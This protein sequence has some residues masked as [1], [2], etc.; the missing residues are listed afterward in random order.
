MVTEHGAA[1]GWSI[2]WRPAPASRARSRAV[3]LPAA[4]AT[5]TRTFHS[6][7]YS[8]PGGFRLTPSPGAN[9]TRPPRR[10]YTRPEGGTVITRLAPATRS[11]PAWWCADTAHS[12]VKGDVGPTSPVHGAQAG[13]W[14]HGY[15]H[16]PG[17]GRF[18]RERPHLRAAAGHG[19]VA[20]FSRRPGARGGGDIYP[21]GGPGP[22]A[23]RYHVT[24][25]TSRGVSGTASQGVAG[26]KDGRAPT[27]R[28][29]LVAAGRHVAAH[30]GAGALGDR[31]ALGGGR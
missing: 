12:P 20:V 23:H 13:R 22:P 26:S 4:D 14:H 28:R 29:G 7:P 6:A 27:V 8:P 15:R 24:S 9:A 5:R 21:G 31:A 10:I 25:P 1:G 30:R 18:Y 2:T 11:N 19:D 16:A 3:R 17:A